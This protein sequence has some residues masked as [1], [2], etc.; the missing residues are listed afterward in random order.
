MKERIIELLHQ[1]QKQE[2]IHIL[3]AVE[4]GS[5]AW[6]LDSPNSD[7]DVRF[8]YVRPTAWYLSIEDKS[9][10]VKYQV[11]DFD[12][13]GFD[14]KK[15]L[16]L[17][18]KSNPSIYEWLSSPVS[19]FTQFNALETLIHFAH[20]QFNQRASFLHYYHMAKQN[21]ELFFR[22]TPFQ[23]KRLFYVLRPIL[24]CE[25]IKKEGKQ[26]LL[27]FEDLMNQVL[28]DSLLIHAMNDWIMMKKQ[29]VKTW[30]ELPPVIR[31][32]IDDSLNAL[33]QVIPIETKS[34]PIE[35]LDHFFIEMLESVERKSC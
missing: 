32:F 26:P 15:A 21:R 27:V 8:I 31:T 4:T 6:G 10:Q 7:Y 25:Y 23:I 28:T 11:Q 16:K 22:E 2:G 9:D 35:W 13:L 5:R 18:S 12:F 29:G 19:Y 33:Q 14:L 30:H 24:C 1:C 3:F 34:P 20:L 17:M